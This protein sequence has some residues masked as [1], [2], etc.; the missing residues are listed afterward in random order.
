MDIFDFIRNRGSDNHT[1]MDFVTISMPRDSMRELIVLIAINTARIGGVLKE[2]RKN[3]SN[4][5]IFE[6]ESVSDLGS[7][8]V[9]I[10]S[11]SAGFSHR[12]LA[13]ELERFVAESKKLSEQ[14]MQVH[15]NKSNEK[16]D[17]IVRNIFGK[18]GT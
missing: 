7:A 4:H 15:M 10:L 14:E 6:L 9:K 1:A 3:M 12:E 17:E 11:E 13:D 18:E 8:M 5:D 2:N 16:F